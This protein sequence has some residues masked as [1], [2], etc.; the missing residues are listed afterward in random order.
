MTPEP[1]GLKSSFT[2]LWNYNG[3]RDYPGQLC[4]DWLA[5]N[6]F[7]NMRQNIAQVCGGKKH[8]VNAVISQFCS[9][10]FL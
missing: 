6:I 9:T 2:G 10:H 4:Y 1:E 7:V 3:L 8:K 5:G